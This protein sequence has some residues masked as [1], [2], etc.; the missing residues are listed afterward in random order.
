[1][2]GGRKIDD[3]TSWIGARSKDSVFPK[4]V[5]TKEEHSAMSA[6]AEHEYEDTTD[7]IK[8]QQEMGTA[9]A[10]AHPTK[11]SYRN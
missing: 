9:K 6:G 1:M 11:A 3:H 5:H 7:M 10:K 8:K 4:G 2:A